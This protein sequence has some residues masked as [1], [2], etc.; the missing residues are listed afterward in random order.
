M[1]GHC[2]T[3]SAALPA[4]AP[5]ALSRAALAR[6]ARPAP[7]PLGPRCAALR[8]LGASAPS[9]WSSGAWPRLARRDPSPG[10]AS[11]R[12]AASASASPATGRGL[13][14]AAND[15]W[16]VG[17]GSLSPGASSGDAERLPDDVP[18]VIRRLA[19]LV[20]PDARLFATAIACLVAAALA[21]MAL[22]H[23]V[24]RAVFAAV[25]ERSQA[26]FLSAVRA[27]AALSVAFGVFSGLRGALFTFQQFKLVRRLRERLLATYLSMEVSFFDRTDVGSMTSRLN[28][29][30]QAVSRCAGL[31]FNVLLRNSIQALG[32]FAYL[33]V[34]SPPVA[35]ATLA[36]SLLLFLVTGLYGRFARAAARA[37][38]D[39]IERVNSCAEEAL[40]LARVVRIFGGELKDLQAVN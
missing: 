10:H 7:S 6:A 3:C 40:S 28:S 18:L 34:L 13:F 20:R 11:A 39:S 36:V 32:G 21:E 16:A 27:V 14:Q 35:G 37:M 1:A 9:G 2:A 17:W 24:T 8:S 19:G 30:C 29:D 25:A 26:G 4:A 12:V 33:V 31:N 22:P 38:Q 5:L 23:F 15:W